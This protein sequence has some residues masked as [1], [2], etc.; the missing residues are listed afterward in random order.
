[1]KHTYLVLS[2]CSVPSRQKASPFCNKNTTQFKNTTFI[3]CILQQRGKLVS[4]LQE[5]L[6]SASRNAFKRQDQRKTALFINRHL[7][8]VASR[9]GRENNSCSLTVK[10]PLLSKIIFS[11]ELPGGALG[12]SRHVA[13]LILF[14]SVLFLLQIATAWHLEYWSGSFHRFLA[15][16]ANTHK[17]SV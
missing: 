7:R 4:N 16:Q 13:Y 11:G 14:N 17:P 12:S 5:P 15:K 10:N 8:K 2:S 3:T 6:N 9:T 1:M